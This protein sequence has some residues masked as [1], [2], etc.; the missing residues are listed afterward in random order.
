MIKKGEW[1]LL[2]FN[3]IYIIAFTIYYIKIQ[4]F[5]FLWYIAIMLV[6]FALVAGTLR[7]TKFSYAV[8]WG[9]SIWG[10]LHMIGGGVSVGGKVLYALELIPIWVTENFYVLKYDQFVHGYLYF[11]MTFVVYHLLKKNLNGKFNNWIIY[12]VVVLAS[13]GISTLNEIAEFAAVLALPQTGVGGYFNTAWD[14]V[15]NTLGAILAVIV[16]HLKIRKQGF[17]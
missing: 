3:L 15:F 16:L 14:L 13:V 4:D 8:L 1:I 7:K 2:I 12:P 9:L 11:V 17:K 6:L 10:L 5:E